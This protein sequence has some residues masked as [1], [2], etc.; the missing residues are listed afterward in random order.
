MVIFS[1]IIS[2][3]SS[4]PILISLYVGNRNNKSYSWQEYDIEVNLVS[5]NKTTNSV[6]RNG[7]RNNVIKYRGNKRILKKTLVSVLGITSSKLQIGYITVPSGDADKFKIHIIHKMPNTKYDIIS[8]LYQDKWDILA[9]EIKNI[10]HISSKWNVECSLSIDIF[11]PA[12]TSMNGKLN[13]QLELVEDSC[14]IGGRVENP[15]NKPMRL[16]TS[17]HDEDGELINEILNRPNIHTISISEDMFG[18]VKN[19][20]YNYTLTNDENN[21]TMPMMGISEA[22]PEI[23]DCQHDDHFSENYSEETI[24]SDNGLSI[25]RI[26][27]NQKNIDANIYVIC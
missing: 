23:E 8:T 12:L 24:I 11:S 13:D 1:L 18:S 21:T 10:Y 19:D 25:K 5:M 2:L 16:Y 27:P 14:S 9:R 4:I 20:G 6:D 22:T 7:A 15:T 26:I 3:V 17:T